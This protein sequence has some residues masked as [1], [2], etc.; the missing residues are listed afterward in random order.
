MT[1]R[2]SLAAA[3]LSAALFAPAAALAQSAENWEFKAAIYGYFPTIGGTG[4]FKPSGGSSSASVDIDTIL[5]NLK[6]TFMGQFEARKGEWGLFTDVVYMDVGADKSGARGLT[7]GDRALPAGVNGSASY[8]LK[9]WLWTLAGT[10]RAVSTPTY[11]LDVVAG[12]RLLDIEQKL[13]WSLAGNVGSIPVLDR[14][15]QR[16]ADLSNWDAII[17][18]KG[19]AS[20][21]EDRR[22][23]VPYYFDVGTGQSRF[24]WQ[25]LAGLGYQ[26]DWGGVVAAWRYI[27]YDMKSGKPLD[28]L[29]F[30]GPGIA[31][32]FGW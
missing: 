32:V 7:L 24:T 5:D 19:R 11:Q 28:D 2:N 15:G 31:V 17:G 3:V 13:G 25:A 20:L 21:G 16:Q 12:A 10:Y 29:N 14:S 9:G 26:F 22:W 1:P 6:F 4:N 8:D 27:D 30:N 18:V 23:F